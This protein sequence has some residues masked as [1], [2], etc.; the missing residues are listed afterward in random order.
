RYGSADAGAGNVESTV[1]SVTGTLDHRFNDKWAFHSV[2]RN[3]EYS[4]GRNNYTT[5][6]RVT[7]GPI[8]T[9]TPSVTQRNRNDRG[10]L[11]QN[12]LTQ[13]AE[14]WGIQHTLLY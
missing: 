12:E 6:S 1:K 4:L 5:V 2:V 8:P 10:T 11:W 7:D 13:K 3:Y 14:T 9:V